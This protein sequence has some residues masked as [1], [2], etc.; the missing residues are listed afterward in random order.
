IAQALGASERGRRF[1]A[2]RVEPYQRE[3][4]WHA[5]WSHEFIYQTVR[6]QMEPILELVRGYYETDYDFPGAI[7]AMR[8]DIEVASRE[9]LQGLT[10][11]ALE[12]M[13]AANEW[14][15]RMAPLTPDHHFYIDQGA[16]AHLRLVLLAV[17]QKLGESGHLNQ[18]AA[19]SSLRCTELPQLIGSSEA[20]GP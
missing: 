11:D 18:P 15:L 10:G 19:V 17:G 3:F 6:E 8:E 13:R 20:I 1:I 2:E 5:V 14:K 7:S 16:N 12:E 4:G 9:I